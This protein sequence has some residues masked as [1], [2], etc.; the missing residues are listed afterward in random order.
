MVELDIK[1]HQGHSIWITYKL[2]K[3]NQRVKPSAKIVPTLIIFQL[4][5]E[6]RVPA[7]LETAIKIKIEKPA[8]PS[9][10]FG[11]PNNDAWGVF[12]TDAQL[13]TAFTLQDNLASGFS[14]MCCLSTDNWND[15]R[16]ANELA[17]KS[18]QR[19]LVYLS[20]L[21]KIGSSIITHFSD[22]W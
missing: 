17:I 3:N 19:A 21:L 18:T 15:A 10:L 16:K 8:N 1:I 12:I 9:Q 22:C 14:A 6:K 20:F 2:S 11:K 7:K 5:R 13:R 4:Q